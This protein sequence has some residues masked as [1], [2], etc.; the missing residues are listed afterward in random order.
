MPAWRQSIVRPPDCNDCSPARKPSTAFIR[1]AATTF[2]T[3]LAAVVLFLILVCAA[4]W[5]VCAF[6]WLCA[7][8]VAR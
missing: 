2:W 5:I 6:L 4:I 7:G 1:P 8:T 3:D